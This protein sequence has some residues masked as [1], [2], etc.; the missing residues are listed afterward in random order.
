MKSIFCCAAAGKAMTA[1]AA[2]MSNLRMEP[3]CGRRRDGTIV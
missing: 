2:A 3:P 1:A